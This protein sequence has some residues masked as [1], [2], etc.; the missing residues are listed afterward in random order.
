MDH[1]VDNVSVILEILEVDCPKLYGILE[2]LGIWG[3]H[4]SL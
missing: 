2:I 3:P 4:H 1:E